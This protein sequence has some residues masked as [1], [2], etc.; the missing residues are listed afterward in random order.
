V[1]RDAIVGGPTAR[2]Y[3]FLEIVEKFDEYCAAG[4][5]IASAERSLAGTP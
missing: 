2:A 4:M 5:D 1:Q 3:R